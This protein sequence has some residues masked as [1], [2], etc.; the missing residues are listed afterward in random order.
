MTHASSRLHQGFQA[1]RLSTVGWPLLGPSTQFA[2]ARHTAR[3]LSG[4]GERPRISGDY[5][6]RMG[7]VAG[8]MCPSG[9]CMATSSRGSG[10]DCSSQHGGRASCAAC[11]HGG[12]GASAHHH[13]ALS[14]LGYAG[15]RLPTTAGR[16]A[17]GI[18]LDIRLL[19]RPHAGSAAACV[20]RAWDA[21]IMNLDTKAGAAG[22][23]CAH[24]V[25][26][27]CMWRSR[28]HACYCM[29]AGLSGPCRRLCS[30]LGI[31]SFISVHFLPPLR[32]RGWVAWHVASGVHCGTVLRHPPPATHFRPRLMVLRVGH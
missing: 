29:E 30:L 8:S 28:M 19:E 15:H 14:P 5:A 31:V 18:E 26:A 7:D 6:L 27:V 22:G 32:R 21:G 2:A 20:R 1:S 13:S 11:S 17:A 23:K 12:D 10:L 24:V 4:R 9:R 25:W 3:Q 16:Q